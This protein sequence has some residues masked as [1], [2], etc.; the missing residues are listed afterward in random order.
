MAPPRNSAFA[1]AALWPL[2][3]GCRNAAAFCSGQP[4]YRSL[5][6]GSRR[7]QWRPLPVEAGSLGHRLRAAEITR[8]GA[9]RVC[10][11]LTLQ[12]TKLPASQVQV[13]ISVSADEVTAAY[14][15]AVQEL[16]LEGDLPTPS[17][18]DAVTAA[19]GAP[20]LASA[21][22]G[23]VISSAVPTA[24]AQLSL[25]PI[26]Q[27]R[28]GEDDDAAALVAAFTPTAP[29]AFSV[30]MDVW[31]VATLTGP[32]R[33]LSVTV[34]RGSTSGDAASDAA[35]EQAL[36]M[37]RAQEAT[38]VPADGE[39]AIAGGGAVVELAG[40]VRAPDG[41]R[42]PP[43]P[44]GIGDGEPMELVL[45]PGSGMAA[46]VDAVL[47]L[48]IGETGVAEVVFPPT[49]GRVELRG[50][51]AVFDVK[52]LAV[53]EAVLPPLDDTFAA[54]VAPP[55]KTLDE[56]RASIRGSLA[57]EAAAAEAE[58]VASAVEDA[59]VGVAA[60]DVPDTL[61]EEGVRR[62][63]GRM[64]TA[65]KEQ[66]TVPPDEWA[67][68]VT[69][70]RYELY[71]TGA[72]AG[73]ERG[74]A[75]NFALAAVAAAEGLAADPADVEDQVD[76]ARLALKGAPMEDEEAVRDRIRAHLERK[77]VMDV[78]ME[79]AVVTWVEPEVAA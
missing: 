50:V 32:Y 28:L 57:A 47:G 14:E 24:L 22:V 27:V 54:A 37:L 33:G 66:G 69:P 12:S 20:A 42:G 46:F 35:V 63:F 45:T 26:G 41:S 56:L 23:R 58:A 60:V 16:A 8:S 68:M 78:L 55:A 31:P 65:L 43:L 72:R 2:C 30:T 62:R 34:P 52:L 29:L 77:A 39:V 36:A 38:Y 6:G 25:S 40:F 49:A 79:H 4:A 18:V 17:T 51:A 76:L 10:M 7:V 61:V 15:A 67:A 71:K 11:A 1:P 75:L 13:D 21:S 53:T 44:N 48:R 73:V 70:E 74:L 5:V 19:F 59:L 9:S 64:L 3:K